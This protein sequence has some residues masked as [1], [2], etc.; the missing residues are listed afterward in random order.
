MNAKCLFINLTI[1]LMVLLVAAC[2]PAAAGT[3]ITPAQIPEVTIKAVDYA[4]KSPAQLKAGLVALTLVNEGQEPHHAQLARLKPGITLEQFQE[5][6]KQEP[7]AAMAMI[8]FA[9]G[10]GALDPG[11]S[12]QVTLNLAP[13]HYVWLDFIPS[14]GDG[15]PHLAK[16]M[17]APLEVVAPGESDPRVTAPPQVAGTVKLMDFSFVLP[18]EIK[19]GP[20]VWQVVNEGK[21]P[22]EMALIK[23][24][25]GKTVADVQAFMHTPEGAPPFS[26]IGGFQALT[27]GES[28]WLTLDLEVGEYVALCAVPDEA[29]KPHTEHGMLLPFRVK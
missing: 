13:G 8:T 18:S 25:E 22:H 4:F 21:Q 16:G 28:G 10:P 2:T 20:Q 6:L 7:P 5:A 12:Q 9:G 1:L 19:T 3:Q 29:G 27:S 11:L 17:M 26:S 23:L 14:P 15:M 24:A